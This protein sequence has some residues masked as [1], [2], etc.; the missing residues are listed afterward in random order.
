MSKARGHD[1]AM[2]GCQGQYSFAKLV[3]QAPYS[4]AH[5]Q[6]H[7]PPHNHMLYPLCIYDVYIYISAIPPMPLCKGQWLL[8]SFCLVFSQSYLLPYIL[9]SP[10]QHLIH[11]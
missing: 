5:T 3:L 2:E 8:C 10:L 1:A 9:F 6:I 11:M 7:L 4:M